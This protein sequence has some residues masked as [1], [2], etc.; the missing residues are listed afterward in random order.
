MSE[1][2]NRSV[3]EARASRIPTDEP[4]VIPE[5]ALGI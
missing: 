4:I 3:I 2:R 1:S 5:I